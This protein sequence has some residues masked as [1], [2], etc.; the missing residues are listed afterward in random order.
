MHYIWTRLALAAEQV[1]RNARRVGHLSDERM[2]ENILLWR[3]K[4]SQFYYHQTVDA[5]FKVLLQAS[6][7][8]RHIIE[9][10]DQWPEFAEFVYDEEHVLTWAAHNLADGECCSVSRLDADDSFSCDWLEFAEGHLGLDIL[11]MYGYHRQYN[12]E[13]GELS[14][15][16]FHGAPMFA[17]RFVKA[18]EPVSNPHALVHGN[19]QL[20]GAIG[21]HGK[22]PSYRGSR[23]ARGCFAM[24]RITGK[25]TASAWGVVGNSRLDDMKLCDR[26]DPAFVGY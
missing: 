23:Y 15:M 3:D 10:Y 17:T 2:N 18:W 20:T 12:T 26:K 16:L 5:P 14:R 21:N 22:Y 9:S 8:Y 6:E 19:C 13:T 11:M 1:D 24:Q 25:N 4:A 7:C